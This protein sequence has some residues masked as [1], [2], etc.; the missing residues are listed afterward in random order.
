MVG[1]IKGITIELNGDTTKLDKALRSVVRE[2]QTLQRQLSDV[3]KALKMDP[4]NTEL[5]TQKE[6]LLGEEIDATKRKLEMLRQADEQ[7]TEDMENGVEGAT[8]KHN[9]LQRQIATT[10]AKEKMLQRELDKLK[11]VPSKVDQIAE[12]MAKTG[13]K[14]KDAGDKMKGFGKSY[15]KYVTAPLTAAGTIGAKK[16]AELDKT[17]QLTNATMQNNTFV[18]A[19]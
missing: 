14:I 18:H 13:E 7:V 15:S 10:E 2:T 9:E 19:C 16:F 1:N 8:E 5:V 11:E 6:R 12:S 4:G 3:E 17:M